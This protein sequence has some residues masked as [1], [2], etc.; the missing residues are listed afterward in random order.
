MGYL[1]RVYERFWRRLGGRPWTYILRD[2]WEQYEIF[3][4]IGL[5]AI[6][7]LMGYFCPLA[8]ALGGLGIL[9]GGF[10]LGHLFWGTKHVRGQKD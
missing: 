3:W 5:L 4:I 2:A 9:L 8:W 7:I 1:D 6:G 10:I